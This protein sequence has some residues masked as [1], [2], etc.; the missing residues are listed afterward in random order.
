MATDLPLDKDSA[1]E[2]GNQKKSDD[3]H[4]AWS[5]DDTNDDSHGSNQTFVALDGFDSC[6]PEKRYYF[7]YTTYT[8]VH[9]YIIQCT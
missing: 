7:V 3:A 2:N 9:I 5:D 6:H 8:Y 4:K 1:V